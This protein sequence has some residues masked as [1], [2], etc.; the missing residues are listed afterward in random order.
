MA[1]ATLRE[2][3]RRSGISGFAIRAWRATNAVMSA[4]PAPPSASVCVEPQPCS[5]T[6]RIA[7]TPSI[8]PAVS[9]TAPRRSAPWPMPIPLW[10]SISRSAK[11]AVATPTGMLMK[12]I[13]CQLIASVSAPPARRPIEPPA[14]ATKP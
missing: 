13:Q 7:Y 5:A 8:S 12:K 2:R 1:P 4:T 11:N 9:S 14:E 3:N 6:P 10:S